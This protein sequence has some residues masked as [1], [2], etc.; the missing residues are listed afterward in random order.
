LSSLLFFSFLRASFIDLI[1][2]QCACNQINFDFNIV[3][4][5]GIIQKRGKF[6]WLAFK[7][8]AAYRVGAGRSGFHR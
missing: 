3:T 5:E 4:E 7:S 6:G 1:N 8:E 2:V